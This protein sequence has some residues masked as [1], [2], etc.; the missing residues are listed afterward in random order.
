MPSDVGRV[1]IPRLPPFPARSHELNT[2]WLQS[3]VLSRLGS[4]LSDDGYRVTV[5]QSRNVLLFVARFSR[6]S[7]RMGINSY[8]GIVARFIRL[9]NSDGG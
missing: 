7:S 4:R 1:V 5:A 6:V 2:S 3:V 8:T 9:I